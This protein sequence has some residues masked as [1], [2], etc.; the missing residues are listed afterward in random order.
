MIAAFF[1]IVVLTG[2]MAAA[3]TRPLITPKSGYTQVGAIVYSPTETG[4]YLIQSNNFGVVFGKQYGAADETA[5]ANTGVF[6][7]DGIEMDKDFFDFIAD[8]RE[9]QDDKKRFKILGIDNERVYFKGV[10][11][12]K[13]RG[14]SEDH[15][16][17][18][19][20]STDFQYLKT[21]GYVCRHPLNKVT[22]FQMEIS[23]RSKEKAFSE[24][25]LA[26]GEEF[27]KN[28]QFNNAG[29]KK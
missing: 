17:N 14:L 25:L 10:S 5:V 12:L 28:I 26:V 19:I 22:A 23:Q 20:D 21:A 29:L 18:G 16:N 4:W 2:C 11:C 9:R 24:G 15:K 6:K 13:Y 27:F 1:L 3:P 7:V 8:Q